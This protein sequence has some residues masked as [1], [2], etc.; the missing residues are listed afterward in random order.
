MVATTKG[1][2]ERILNCNISVNTADMMWLKLEWRER[3]SL[4]DVPWKIGRITNR[5]ITN[6][7]YPAWSLSRL[8]ELM[9]SIFP[10]YNGSFVGSTDSGW[11]FECT[12][13]NGKTHL[14]RVAS[15]EIIECVVKTIEMLTQKGFMLRENQ[16][17]PTK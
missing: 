16:E 6:E 4:L 13:S 10:N 15:K 5:K 2:S 11:F 12:I 7:T 17:Q 14:F 1:Q 3:M 8:L 9:P